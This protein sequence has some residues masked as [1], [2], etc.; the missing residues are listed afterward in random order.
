[1]EEQPMKPARSRLLGLLLLLSLLV[2]LEIAMA[3]QEGQQPRPSATP[4]ALYLPLAGTVV[5]A[6]NQ[7]I[8]RFSGN[9]TINRF[10]R[11]D[12][13]I[14]AIGI[15]RGT[16]TDLAGQVIR[17]GLQTIVLP[18]T[19]GSQ[20]AVASTTPPLA[21]P[22]MMPASFTNAQSGRIMLAQATSC[23]ILH[24]AIGGTAVNLLGVIVNLSPVTLDIS[25]DSAGPL[26]ALVCQILALLGQ[27][28]NVVGLLN[29]LLGVL[30]GLLGGV[31]G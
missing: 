9:V 8:G 30:T 19:V 5:D 4:G 17:S 1:M 31:I 3:Q 20:S 11:Q 10:A 18:V 25:G 26:G 28:A 24:L 7:P 6:A 23:G 14:V 15:V 2:P 16:V 29:Q 13:Q 12:N 21:G 27:V 22:R